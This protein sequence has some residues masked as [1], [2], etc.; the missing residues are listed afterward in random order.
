MKKK[1]TITLE[2]FEGIS[3]TQSNQL[4]GGFSQSFSGQDKIADTLIGNN[5]QGGNC[6]EGC[7]SD[8]NVM[9]NNRVGCG[10]K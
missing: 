8:N 2:N 10:T 7:G 5:C 4:M 9:C 1:I 3:E 6:V